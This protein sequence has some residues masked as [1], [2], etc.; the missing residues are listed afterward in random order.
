VSVLDTA[1][2]LRMKAQYP[3]LWRKLI[4]AARKAEGRT[5]VR[6]EA[7]DEKRALYAVSQAIR[8][9]TTGKRARKD[10]KAIKRAMR[11]HTTTEARQ[12]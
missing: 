12:A 4:K 10:A 11:D 5:P 9:R 3:A 6:S 2:L 1:T 8:G 7:G